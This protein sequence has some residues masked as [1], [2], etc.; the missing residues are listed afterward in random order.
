MFRYDGNHR[1][2]KRERKMSKEEQLIEE[3]SK[4]QPMVIETAYLYATNY[5][6]YGEDVTEKWVTAVQQT[7]I[8]EKAYRQGY[9][10]A[11]EELRKQKIPKEEQTDGDLVSRQAVLDLAKDLTFEGGCKHRCVDVTEIHCLPSAEKTA[12]Y[13]ES[14]EGNISET[15]MH[16]FICAFCD[17]D[18]CVRGT[19]ECEFEQWKEKEMWKVSL[20]KGEEK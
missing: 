3:L 11:L 5:T 10:D 4:M 6:R 9:C 14:E 12:P 16:H 8:L 18:K 13:K 7:S 20:K 15:S 19:K 17:N 1:S 2:R